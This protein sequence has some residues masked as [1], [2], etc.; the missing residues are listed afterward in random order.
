MNINVNIMLVNTLLNTNK[1]GFTQYIFKTYKSPNDTIIAWIIAIVINN[2]IFPKY[3]DA[4]EYSPS[5]STVSIDANNNNPT[6]ND[7]TV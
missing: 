7:N 3:C 4:A 5:A 1:A 6:H 2:N